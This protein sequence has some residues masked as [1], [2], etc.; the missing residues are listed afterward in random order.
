[1]HRAER[2]SGRA[3]AYGH[4]ANVYE[5]RLSCHLSNSHTYL[6]MPYSII[7][8]LL[9]SKVVNGASIAFSYNAGESAATF[10]LTGAHEL[11]I[12]QVDY[13]SPA[14]FTLTLGALIT[15]TN[16]TGVTWPAG[17][18][19]FLQVAKPDFAYTGNWDYLKGDTLPATMV[20]SP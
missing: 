11:F 17:G 8:G 19:Y 4:G 14:S 6:V 5:L 7:Q 9:H 2:D 16:N 10:N 18:P 15:I 12:N 13:Y 1:M 3:Y 20:T